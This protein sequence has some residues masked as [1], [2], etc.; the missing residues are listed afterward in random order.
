MVG[1]TVVAVT[2]ATAPD[3]PEVQLDSSTY[4]QFAPARPAGYPVFLKALM[5]L[6]GGG[7]TLIIPV[8][9]VLLGLCCVYLTLALQNLGLWWPVAACAGLLAGVNPVS[10]KYAHALLSEGLFIPATIA[11]AA[12]TANAASR[13]TAGSLFILMAV[14]ALAW[15]V[16]QIG[17]VFIVA[18][19]LVIFGCWRNIATRWTTLFI[20]AVV[21]VLSVYALDAAA[22]SV[23]GKYWNQ[24]EGE[25]VPS[26]VKVAPFS[27]AAMIDAPPPDWAKDD[28]R[29]ILENLLEEGFR[30]VRA[31][32]AE[33]PTHDI[34]THFSLY[35]EMIAYHHYGWDE[36]HIAA[37][38]MGVT[39]DQAVWEVGVD[40][41]RRA[42]LAAMAFFLRDYLALWRPFKVRNPAAVGLYNAYVE[43]RR[44]LPLERL[45]RE[46]SLPIGMHAEPSRIAVFVRPVFAGIGL[47]SLALILAWMWRMAARRVVPPLLAAAAGMA[48]SVHAAHFGV[49]VTHQAMPRYS[50]TMIVLG[51]VACVAGLAWLVTEALPRRSTPSE[52]ARYGRRANG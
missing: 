33:A 48:A 21:P 40:R 45:A 42:P 7:T 41:L 14:I 23:W 8:Q 26:I 2:L 34:G 32:I 38:A 36:R 44:P 37:E 31:L 1:L 39:T 35:Y 18:P 20:C 3:T 25:V 49:A 5:S 52:R 30:P 29:W 15:S 28:P 50:E 11:L 17:G 19:V 13:Q 24:S 12:A 4:L 43:S 51:F 10:V 46:E 22:H 6:G 47:F 16:R 27:K 9:A